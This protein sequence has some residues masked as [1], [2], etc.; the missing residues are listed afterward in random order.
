MYQAINT[1]WQKERY[2]LY[3]RE[4]LPFFN[5]KMKDFLPI[6]HLRVIQSI[7]GLYNIGELR[8]N[9]KDGYFLE[10][11]NLQTGA[12]KRTL[13]KT[14][15]KAR[16]TLVKIGEYKTSLNVKY[17]DYIMPLNYIRCHEFESFVKELP[18]EE[19]F[20]YITNSQDMKPILHDIIGNYSL[21]S[22]LKKFSR[23]FL[24]EYFTGNNKPEGAYVQIKDGEIISVYF[25][26]SCSIYSDLLKMI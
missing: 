11:W 17:L 24:R 19:N 21:N 3:L 20:S 22:K 23:S 12:W 15:K 1:T 13:G 26:F 16:K 10:S 9:V 14:F 18:E 7:Y 25:S 6:D 2:N 8:F 5:A 4:G